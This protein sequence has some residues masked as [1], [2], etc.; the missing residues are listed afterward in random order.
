MPRSDFASN[1]PISGGEFSTCEF[2]S[3][4]LA[5]GHAFANDL[6]LLV[7][8]EPSPSDDVRA[9][10]PDHGFILHRAPKSR[11]GS[12]PDH[13]MTRPTAL[14]QRPGPSEHRLGPGRR[15]GQAGRGAL[16]AA[17][18][19]RVRGATGQNDHLGHDRDRLGCIAQNQPMRGF[20]V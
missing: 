11:F 2:S 9:I 20:H 7:E 13:A 10:Y 6:A 15:D 3:T 12:R 4:L 17:A 1:N 16:P 8:D 18:Y 14:T 5:H 19:S